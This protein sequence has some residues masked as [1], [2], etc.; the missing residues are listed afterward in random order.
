MLDLLALLEHHFPGYNSQNQIVWRGDGSIGGY[1]SEFH[2]LPIIHVST[3]FLISVAEK[4]ELTKQFNLH[5]PNFSHFHI[6]E[7]R[8][9][10]IFH[11]DIFTLYLY[12]VEA[13]LFRLHRVPVHEAG[14]R[15]V[16]LEPRLPPANPTVQLAPGHPP[17]IAGGGQEKGSVTDASILCTSQEIKR[18]TEDLLNSFPDLWARTP[19][20]CGTFK[21]KKT[22][23]PVYFELK[24]KDFRPVIQA[25]RFLPPA[26]QDA[27]RQLISGMLGAN[28]IRPMYCRFN[29]NSVYVKK[30][31][32][33]I[34]LTEWL[35]LGYKQEDYH[36]NIPHPFKKQA[37]RHTLDWSDLNNQLMPLAI[38]G[39]DPKQIIN[40]L[41][42]NKLI[43]T[44]DVAS[45]YHS[46]LL[47]RPSQMYTG[48]SSGL[49][50]E[51]QYAY[52]R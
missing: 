2:D 21:D 29:Q 43:S 32:E 15:H 4:C 41:Q 26:R 30:A 10:Q 40:S 27:A 7:K 22:G 37:L 33:K 48:F 12:E 28:L 8:L 19:W 42:E 39:C 47:S 34:S 1:Q 16:P 6:S 25:P 44:I 51:P 31:I 38:Q 52:L 23:K 20:D 17:P 18:K 13:S 11:K 3:Q 35:S 14:S 46:L 5:F 9:K 45:S 36:P 49:R 50:G 24:L